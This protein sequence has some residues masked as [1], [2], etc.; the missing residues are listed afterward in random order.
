MK[1]WPN[2]EQVQVSIHSN[3]DCL[4]GGEN[5]DFLFDSDINE[6]S[7]KNQWGQKQKA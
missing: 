5:M 4:P 7:V 3:R 6:P 1:L 2:G